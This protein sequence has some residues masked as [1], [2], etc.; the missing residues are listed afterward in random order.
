[1]VTV[2]YLGCFS[3]GP[4]IIKGSISKV[5]EGEFENKG[6]GIRVR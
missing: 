5:L 4:M 6:S 3:M 1:M 2:P